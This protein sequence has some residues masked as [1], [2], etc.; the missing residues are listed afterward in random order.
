M[1]ENRRNVIRILS[2]EWNS[3]EFMKW[4]GGQASIGYS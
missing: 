3:N 4:G 1:H 2:S